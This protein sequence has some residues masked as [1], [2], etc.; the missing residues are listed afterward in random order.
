MS[1]EIVKEPDDLPLRD[2]EHC[3][4]CATKTQFWSKKDVAVC[5]PCAETHEEADVPS[6][7]E[8]CRSPHGRGIR[9]AA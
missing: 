7:E 2:R 8:W 5:P 1:I 3:C 4:F 6:K 9:V